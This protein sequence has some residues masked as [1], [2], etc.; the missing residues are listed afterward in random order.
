M[1]E[2][3]KVVCINNYTRNVFDEKMCRLFPLEECIK[4]RWHIDE[5]LNIGEI[6][7]VEMHSDYGYWMVES[8]R[9]YKRSRFITL[10]EWREKRIDEI[11]ND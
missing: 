4:L 2:K 1:S 11:L 7:D 3:L 9:I 5:H 8:H 10:A 6:Y